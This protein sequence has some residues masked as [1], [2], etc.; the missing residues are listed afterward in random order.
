ME[1]A[2]GEIDHHPLGGR[3]P[4]PPAD[5]VDRESTPYWRM[6]WPALN[7]EECLPAQYDPELAW[8]Q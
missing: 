6:P 3:I 7:P 2:T 5:A 4:L 1:F 8:I